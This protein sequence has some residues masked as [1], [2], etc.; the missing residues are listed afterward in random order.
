MFIYTIREINALKTELDMA[1]AE[2]RHME[3]RLNDAN[4]ELSAIKATLEVNAMWLRTYKNVYKL[5]LQ[6]NAELIKAN[7]E[8]KRKNKDLEISLRAFKAIINALK[9]KGA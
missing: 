4:A 2:L 5:R 1:K 9:R 6:E 3:H 7:E 8:L